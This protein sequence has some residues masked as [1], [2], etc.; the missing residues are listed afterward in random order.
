VDSPVIDEHVVHFVV[1]ILTVLVICKF[2]KSIAQALSS[3]PIFDNFATKKKEKK[4]KKKSGDFFLF[5][6]ESSILPQN[7]AK[8]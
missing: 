7:F 8:P 4:E 3:L 1:G 6:S 2:N 5:L